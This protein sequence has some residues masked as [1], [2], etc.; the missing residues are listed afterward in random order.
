[1]Y[2]DVA[3]YGPIICLMSARACSGWSVTT[4]WK[5]LTTSI[6]EKSRP[7]RSAPART[8][9][10]MRGSASSGKKLRITP[11]PISPASSIILMPVAPT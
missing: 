10:S 2:T 11:S 8:W 5:R 9:A 4:V 7:A 1:M 6:F 3:K